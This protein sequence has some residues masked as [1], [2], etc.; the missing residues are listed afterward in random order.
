[1]TVSSIVSQNLVGIPTE[2]EGKTPRP[3]LMHGPVTL[4]PAD[5]R[6][7]RAGRQAVSEVV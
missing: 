4:K 6:I 1:M 7:A 2:K 3:K 5:Q